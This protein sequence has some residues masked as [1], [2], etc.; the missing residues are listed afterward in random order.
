M[1]TA[2][3]RGTMFELL[4]PVSDAAP[5]VPEASVELAPTPPGSARLLIVEDNDDLRELVGDVLALAGYEV[6]RAQDS[7]QALTLLALHPFHLLITDVVMPGVNGVELVRTATARNPSLK[8]ITMSGYA[9]S[10]LVQARRLPPDAH[11][12][13]KPFQNAELLRLVGEVLGG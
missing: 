2:L 13:R 8:A 5:R 6:H 9:W 3:G 12:L 1:E 4:I 7:A 11:F 10:E